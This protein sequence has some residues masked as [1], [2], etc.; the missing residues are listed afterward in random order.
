MWPPCPR[1]LPRADPRQVK[2]ALPPSNNREVPEMR[3]MYAA[4]VGLVVLAVLLGVSAVHA[5][6][7][8]IDNMSR[9]PKGSEFSTTASGRRRVLVGRDGLHYTG[10]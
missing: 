6:E 2:G 1:T 9:N 10:R 7:S 5:Y 3:G 8:S 4:R